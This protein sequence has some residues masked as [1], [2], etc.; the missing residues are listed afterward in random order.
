MSGHGGRGFVDAVA[1]FAAE[2]A[3]PQVAAIA[4]GLAAP[5]RVA[6]AGRRGVGRRTVANALE[7]LGISVTPDRAADL[8][9]YVI[10]EVAKPED[11]AT[12][13]ALAQPVLVVLNKSD[14][15]GR[16]AAAA[17]SARL[18]A[19]VE[20]MAALLAVAAL[21]GRLDGPLWAALQVLAAEPADLSCAEHF[22]T[23]PHPVPRRVRQQLCD[24]LDLPG[25]TQAV[26]AAR[27]DWPAAQVRVLL[28]RL[29][30]IDAVADRVS[31]VGAAVR[32]QRLLDAVAR[33]AALAVSDGR[34]SDFLLRDDTVV[35]RMAAA[36]QVVQAAGLAV[37]A[38]D[39]ADAAT[40]LRQA[41][42]WQRYSRGP[43]AA[44]HHACGT[45][46]A[47]GLLRLW[48]GAGGPAQ[49]PA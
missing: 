46:I 15:T 18:A 37:D 3:N 41:A 28:R 2:V 39:T 4:E 1:R 5:L 9:V 11:A 19:P 16:A 24:T 21:G 22:V 42:R 12:L 17:V 29:S 25:I 7:C 45:D 20:P 47:R 40:Q 38:V 10:A 13:A 14:L 32:Y 33:L 49:G 35:A 30:G 43:V 31:A 6:V 44:V 26:A 48:S 36:V 23:G 27:Q 8:V 34:I